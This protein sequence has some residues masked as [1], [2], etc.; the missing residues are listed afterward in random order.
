MFSRAFIPP[1]SRVNS[2]GPER[3][4]TRH[5]CHHWQGRNPSTP[6][7]GDLPSL[8]MAARSSR[9]ISTARVM[10]AED[11]RLLPHCPDFHTAMAHRAHGIVA[12]APLSTAGCTVIAPRDTPAIPH[13]H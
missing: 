3:S 8:W 12:G 1:W 13:A 6:E 11:R 7:S 5:R 4:R 9:L 10:P 2:T